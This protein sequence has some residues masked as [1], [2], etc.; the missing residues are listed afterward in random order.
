MESLATFSF[1]SAFIFLLK[2]IFAV[3]TF[4]LVVFVFL[5]FRQVQLMNRVLRTQIASL[6]S[7]FSLF[8]LLTSLGLFGLV[9][10]SFLA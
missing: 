8:L 2:V 3:V 4:G 10:L 7:V 6:F 5:V 1:D 9:L